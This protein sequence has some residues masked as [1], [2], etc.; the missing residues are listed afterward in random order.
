MEKRLAE[1]KA[2][3]R[4]A[5]DAVAF[6]LHCCMLERG[7]R[8]VAITD[9]VDEKTKTELAAAPEGWNKSSDGY[10]FA[11]T[12]ERLSKPVI[13]KSLRIEN[14]LAV[15]AVKK[16]DGK[17]MSFEANVN[18]YVKSGA[19]FKD[20]MNVFSSLSNLQTLFDKHIGS[21]V[22]PPAQKQPPVENKTDPLRDDRF[23]P[24]ARDPLRSGPRLG[25]PG[26]S[27]DYDPDLDPLGPGLNPLGPGGLPA[28]GNLIG[29][30][31][32]LGRGRGRGMKPRFD[33][34]GPLPGSQE[35]DFDDLPPPGPSGPRFPGFGGGRGGGIV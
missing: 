32:L 7:F 25:G 6:V 8:C 30:G 13:V 27:G 11:Y 10:C 29:P 24:K 22:L 16:D 35:P 2:T 14:T 31:Q 1:S 19:D 5:H 28:P 12:H 33:P 18:D 3:F 34:F 26:S 15:H 17:L 21:T 20:S 23:T 4:D 9:A